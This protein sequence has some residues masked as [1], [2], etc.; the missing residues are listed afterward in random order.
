M[1]NKTFFALLMSM[2]IPSTFATL[3][4][5]K[6]YPTTPYTGPTAGLSIQQDM[7]PDREHLERALQEPIG[8]AG[9]YVMAQWSCGTA[10][11]TYT[12]VNK[13]TGKVLTPYIGPEL[14]EHVDEIHANSTLL[15]SKVELLHANP[16]AP[17]YWRYYYV[18]N[19]QK[20]KKIAQQ[21][22]TQDEFYAE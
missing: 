21:E 11:S 6:N 10:C 3:P 9:E 5:F 2:F 15:I 7:E 4:D 16:E 1:K 17:S 14:N 19:Q 18:L 13:R 22:I 12:F 8:F 20:L